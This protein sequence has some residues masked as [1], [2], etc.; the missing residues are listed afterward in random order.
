MV[1]EFNFSARTPRDFYSAGYTK[2]GLGIL[3]EADRARAFLAYVTGAARNARIVRCHWHRY[4]DDPPSGNFTGENGQRGFV[5]ICDTPY[6]ELVGVARK[7]QE[8]VLD[9]RLGK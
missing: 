4:Q 2:P 8:T 6:R 9:I 3:T 7:F 5:D 1:T